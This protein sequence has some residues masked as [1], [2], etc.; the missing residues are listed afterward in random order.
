MF[1]PKK[2]SQGRSDVADIMTVMVESLHRNLNFIPLRAVV[3]CKALL[4]K[5][6]R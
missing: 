1:L 2:N 3:L 5:K 6:I 4:F